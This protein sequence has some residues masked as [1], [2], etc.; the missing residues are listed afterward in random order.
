MEKVIHRVGLE[1]WDDDR[2]DCEGCKRLYLR[3]IGTSYDAGVME[4]F[5]K[6]NH[7]AMRW[8]FDVV[9]VNEGI[10]TVQYTRRACRF[11]G[12]E[13]MPAGLMHRCDQYQPK[14]DQEV[15]KGDGWWQDEK[16]SSTASSADWWQG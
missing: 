1:G 11:K 13:P 14:I 4:K 16:E 15:N 9:V 5:R 7:P 6:V 3:H 10:A 2:V 8:M 12:L